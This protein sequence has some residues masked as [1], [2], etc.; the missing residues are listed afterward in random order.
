MRQHSTVLAELPP[1]PVFLLFC[2]WHCA[3]H[4]S[5]KQESRYSAKYF[6]FSTKR[7]S[8][9]GESKVYYILHK[10]T[11]LTLNSCDFD[12][13]CT[14]IVENFKHFSAFFYTEKQALLW[15]TARTCCPPTDAASEEA[16]APN[17]GHIM[18]EI[19]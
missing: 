12:D 13:L 19:N 5:K 2:L 4:T 18:F 8:T 6:E 16:I 11:R 17:L 1:H 9:V 10:N 7:L 15:C 14:T 3:N